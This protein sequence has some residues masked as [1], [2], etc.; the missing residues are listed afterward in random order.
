MSTQYDLKKILPHDPPMI[1]I[2]DVV[3]M[4]IE[5]K[6][7]T[8]MVKITDDKIFYDKTIN[9]ISP[10]VGIEF[11]AQTIGC[12]SYFSKK[13]EKPEIGFLLGAR[14]YNN[15]LECF[16]KDEIYKIKVT[17]AYSEYEIVAFDCIIYDNNNEEC[18]SST[19]N[20][21]QNE[22]SLKILTE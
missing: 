11:M 15:A 14:L 21:Y 8:S 5:N 9:G 18:A 2:D 19:I 6:T 1:L 16:K 17:E 3:E 20:V 12:Y 4:D 22:D 7:L 13:I 10:V